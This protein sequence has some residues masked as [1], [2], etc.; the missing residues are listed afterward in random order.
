[1]NDKIKCWYFEEGD[2]YQIQV[3]RVNKKNAWEDIKKLVRCDI[4]EIQSIE[5]DDGFTYGVFMNENGLF[6]DDIPNKSADKFVLK[7]PYNWGVNSLCGNYIV[8]KFKYND[9]TGYNDYFD[10]GNIT[11]KELLK[12]WNTAMIPHQEAKKKFIEENNVCVIDAEEMWIEKI[13]KNPQ[14]MRERMPPKM[15]DYY[16]KKIVSNI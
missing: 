5:L 12:K 3:K 11:P 15:F 14:E 2:K 10:I 16:M 4:M 6:E 13:L 8:A 9:K 7:L 1:M